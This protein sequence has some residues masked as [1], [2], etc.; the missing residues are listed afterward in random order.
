[1]IRKP[2]IDFSKT[3]YT[4]IP[5]GALRGKDLTLREMGLYAFLSSLPP[6]WTYSAEGV[7]RWTKDSPYAVRSALDGLIAKGYAVKERVRE[8]GRFAPSAV[9]LLL[10]ERCEPEAKQSGDADYT[11]PPHPGKRERR[12]SGNSGYKPSYGYEDVIF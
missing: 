9:R 2:E 4:K 6:D 10:P 12:K 11:R 5:T 3:K 1:M 8:Q 7:A